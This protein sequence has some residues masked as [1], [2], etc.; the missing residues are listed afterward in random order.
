MACVCWLH[1]S[2][3]QAVK[4][5][6]GEASKMQHRALKLQAHQQK[7]RLSKAAQED[8]YAEVCRS[9]TARELEVCG[10]ARQ[11]CLTGAAQPHGRRA[12]PAGRG[13]CAAP[14]AA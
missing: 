12:A 4:T 1:G 5:V 8:L 10:P 11:A 13:R 7:L 2:R 14:A 3:T 9:L 6:T